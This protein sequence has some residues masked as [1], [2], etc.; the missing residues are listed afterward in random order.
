LTKRKK[1]CSIVSVIKTKQK[2][3]YMRHYEKLVEEAKEFLAEVEKY[4]PKRSNKASSARLRKLSLS[5][6]KNGVEARKE[7]IE[8]D[9]Q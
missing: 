9:K 6:G 1:S 7:L 5:M 8:Q 2:E 3:H 4:E